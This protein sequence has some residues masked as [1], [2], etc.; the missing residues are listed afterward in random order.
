MSS[1]CAFFFSAGVDQRCVCIY[2]DRSIYSAVRE[3]DF[4]ALTSK[5]FRFLLP[6]VRYSRP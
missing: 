1:V 2:V 3:V 6:V 5:V 4:S